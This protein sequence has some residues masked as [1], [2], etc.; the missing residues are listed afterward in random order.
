MLSVLWLV[1]QPQPTGTPPTTST[2]TVSTLTTGACGVGHTIASAAQI[3]IAWTVT[4]PD[5]VNYD[6]KLYENGILLSTQAVTASM[7]YDKT[8]GGAVEG[9]QTAADRS[10][11][12]DDLD[13]AMLAGGA[14]ES[15]DVAGRNG[16]RRRRKDKSQHA[17]PSSVLS[18]ADRPLAAGSARHYVRMLTYRSTGCV[19]PSNPTVRPS[20]PGRPSGALS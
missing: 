16:R 6:A 10:A 12:V 20:R 14:P 19:M 3:R 13:H 7:H 8:I 4:N 15:G 17:A 2:P 1:G 9:D 5:G 11:A 18:C